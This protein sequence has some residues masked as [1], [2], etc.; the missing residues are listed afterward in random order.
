MPLVQEGTASS[1][2]ERQ[3]KLRQL[4]SGRSGGLLPQPVQD[5]AQQRM[6]V[7]TDGVHLHQ[8]EHVDAILDEF[9]AQALAWGADILVSSSAPS[10]NSDA[11][12]ELFLHEIGHV[13][14]G[15]DGGS[16]SSPNDASERRADRLAAGEE[17]PRHQRPTPR[18]AIMRH[19][20]GSGQEE[21]FDPE[22]VAAGRAALEQLRETHPQI[23]WKTFSQDSG[24]IDVVDENPYLTALEIAQTAGLD[25]DF[26]YAALGLYAAEFST[27][28]KE[29]GRT[30]IASDSITLNPALADGD[31]A[32][33]EAVHVLVQKR[34][35][36]V[37]DSMRDAL[38]NAD[39][40]PASLKG[41]RSSH[42]PA[43]IDE[44]FRNSIADEY[45]AYC[46]N[47]KIDAINGFLGF[48]DSIPLPDESADRVPLTEEQVHNI[49]FRYTEAYRST[50]V[51]MGGVP[52]NGDSY[53]VSA[54][55]TISA[56]DALAVDA[57]LSAM[58]GLPMELLEVPVI[59]QRLDDLG[60]AHL[61]QPLPP[62]PGHHSTTETS[63]MNSSPSSSGL[64]GCR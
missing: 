63:W 50:S 11:G 34:I 19:T 5:A 49:T 41:K 55:I 52:H 14:D 31:T 12:M 16:L 56:R 61:Y 38:A 40:D 62:S 58:F 32:L 28:Q 26:Y 60:C 25:P 13:F 36:E 33:H 42:S 15:G 20:P 47:N 54:P 39:I 2:A 53:T 24:W 27:S 17:Q 9:G 22:T 3:E 8:G 57:D 23:T 44:D 46:L 21:G 30:N 43:V 7:E 29:V 6:G 18:G 48:L 37:P 10:V 59:Q 1:N 35:W 51:D 64:H 45:I 4:L